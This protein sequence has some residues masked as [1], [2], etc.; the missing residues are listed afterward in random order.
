MSVDDAR[1]SRVVRRCRELPGKRLF[2]YLDAAG[3]QHSVPSADVNA[4]LREVTGANFTAKTFRTWAGTLCATLEFERAEPCD[5]ERA[6]KQSV[7]RVIE[8][9]AERLGNTPA[10]CRKSYIDPS[11]VS[12]VLEGK[13]V[14]IMRRAR[15]RRVAGLARADAFAIALFEQLARRAAVAADHLS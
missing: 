6:A 11:L 4:Y 12:A 5:S 2:Q 13:L 1:L 9:V 15:K 14:T 3:E 8:R 7:V 10:V